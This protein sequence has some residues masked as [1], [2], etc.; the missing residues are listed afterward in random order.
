MDKAPVIRPALI[1]HADWGKEPNKRWCSVANLGDDGKYRAIAP[2]QVGD[3]S[4]FFERL[5]HRANGGGV[6]AGFDFPI[7]L[8]VS[9]AKRAKIK[10]FPEALKRFGR[11]RWKNFYEPAT[12]ANDISTTRPFYPQGDST[13]TKKSSLAEKLGVADLR[14]R[15][16]VRHVDRPKDAEILFW[17]VG[18]QQVGK[19]AISGWEKLIS[20]A[21]K[22]DTPPAI[23]PFDGPLTDLL[24]RHEFVIAE[25]YPREFYGH[26]NLSV[27][28]SGYPKS[29]RDA[30]IND[31]PA[32]Y[33]W[34][35]K[36]K[37]NIRLQKS[38]QEAINDGFGD[39]KSGED[40][41]DAVVGL[42][43]MIDIV[44]GELPAYFP[45]NPNIRN[46]EGWIL[47]RQ[48]P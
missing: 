24:Y 4:T 7:G 45:D 43:G 38:L 46:I 2:E 20:P 19:A 11:G 29:S 16:E 14:R 8:P 34:A 23:W 39:G 33:D 28:T 25:T 22:W 21:L 47:G 27:G 13:G 37:E 26:L 17:L 10:N 35:K 48:T 9:Y 32:F 15:C 12:S 40:Q 42:F 44:I 6:F 3:V 41:F 31:A 18:P 5:L 36:R 1:A 30:R